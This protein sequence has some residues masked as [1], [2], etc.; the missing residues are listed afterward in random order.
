MTFW[1]VDIVVFELIAKT[2]TYQV[3]DLE[4]LAQESSVADIASHVN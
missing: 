4:N 3:C 1:A 2:W